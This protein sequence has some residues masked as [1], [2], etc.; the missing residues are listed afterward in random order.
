MVFSPC[1][2]AV[3]NPPIH[4]AFLHH[5]PEGPEA[6][7]GGPRR[8]APGQEAVARALHRPR[9]EGAAA[10]VSSLLCLSV[11]G[12]EAPLFR[13]PTTEH[14][15]HI[16]GISWSRVATNC[17]MDVEDGH[18]PLSQLMGATCTDRLG[19]GPV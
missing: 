17:I 10:S 12:P 1:Y 3:S 19:R 9:C 4:P 13:E 6:N 7:Q 14:D 11:A 5:P 15:F 16:P 18:E 8:P 2:G